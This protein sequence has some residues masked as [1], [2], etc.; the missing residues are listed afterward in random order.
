MNGDE[1]PRAS[2]A[3]AGTGHPLL[4]LHG[5]GA[6]KELMLP[7]ATRLT[8]YRVI[9]P[10]LPGFGATEPPPRAWGVDEYS[11]WVVALLDR[12]G[13]ERAHVVGHSNG[14]R[15][16]ITLAATRPERVAKLV[17][18]D[19]AGIRPRHGLRYHWRVRTFKL[20]RAVAASSL[21]PATIRRAA[22]DRADRRGSAD[23]RAASGTLRASMVRL[24]NAD[25]RPQL[26][27]LQAPT[28][29]IWGDRD[30]ETPP[31]DGR[32][33]EQL[34]PDAGLVMFEGAGHF[35]YAEQPDRFCHI[36]DVF[37]RGDAG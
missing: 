19:S 10:D 13:V 14:G 22:A 1:Q 17:L 29:L 30:R 15:I 25:L 28:L 18:A 3:E 33:M 8:G 37:L 20:L 26:A 12:L 24:V 7:I 23:Y 32:T 6:T 27:S 21:V 11:A 36:V 2:L 4:L 9:V 16:A 31:G 5:W 34:I 35:A